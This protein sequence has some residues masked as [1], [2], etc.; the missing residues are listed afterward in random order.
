[1]NILAFDIETVPD[2]TA[3]RRIHN[4]SGL[5][6]EG[7]AQVM[8]SK[9]REQTGESEFLPL[10]LHRVVA[11]SAV[12][13]SGE[14]FKVWSLGN[15]DSPEEEIITR[16]FDGIERYT[17]TLVS[18]NGGGFDLPILHYR[19]LLHGVA[20]SRY[21]DVGDDDRE[22]RWNNY[23]NRFHLRHTDLMDVLSGYQ[24][25][26][27]APL[28]EIA[29]ML[30][31]PGKMGMNGGNVWQLYVSGQ[32]A[33]IRDYCETDA[34]NTYLIFLKWELLRGNLDGSSWE[35]ECRIVR[36]VLQQQQKPHFDEFL[37]HWVT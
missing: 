7:V 12:L 24:L 27:A 31:F 3:G 29:T 25:R 13:R 30:G 33:S 19:S 32:L 17:P 26:G 20:A 2:T 6:D 23:L 1:M 14:Q 37:K 34:L 10:H 22:F 8:F 35:R 9:R 36:D 5:D 15:L 28:D 4:L 21:W 16:F 11:I 18:W